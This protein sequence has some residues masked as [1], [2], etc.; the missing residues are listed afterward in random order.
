MAPFPKDTKS[1]TLMAAGLMMPW[2]TCN[3]SASKSIMNCTTATTS[4][5]VSIA[6]ARSSVRNSSL[7]MPYA[8]NANQNGRNTDARLSGNASNA[9]NGLSPVLA[10]SV[11]SAVS[12][13]EPDGW[14]TV[15][16]IT[17]DGFHEYIANGIVVHNSGWVDELAAFQYPRQTWDNL[18]FGLRLGEDPKVVITTTPKP[19]AVLK[20]IATDPTTIVTRESSYANRRNLTPLFFERI[21]NRYEDTRTGRQEIYAE[22]LDEAE[23][24]L[25]TRQNID[26]NR[27]S[28]QPELIRVVV[29]IDPAVTSNEQSDETGIIVAG[30]GLDELGHPVGYV[31]ADASGRYTPQAWATKAIALCREYQADRI[32][33]EVNNGGEMVEFTLRTIDRTIPYRAVHA[34]RGKAARAEPVAALYEQGKIK[35]VGMFVDLEDQLVGWEPLG[36]DKSPDRLDALVWAMTELMLGRGTGKGPESYDL[37]GLAQA[38]Q[39]HPLGFDMTD[40]KYKDRD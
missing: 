5:H 23:G 19:I 16:D 7:A 22:L 36:A 30:I 2:A 11:V 13:W 4:H 24:A 10:T 1:T 31:L 27:I 15:Y 3:W 14:A 28:H 20:E 35:H 33:A 38:P 21:I 9:I 6:S 32:V 12:T 29:A 17:V 40:P 37:L 39:R 18:L 34:S 25:W 26:A 8:V